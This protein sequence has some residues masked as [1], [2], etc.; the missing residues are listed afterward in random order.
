M[1][2]DAER[3]DGES[4]ANSASVAG[5]AARWVIGVPGVVLSSVLFKDLPLGLPPAVQ[6]P[7]IFALCAAAIV[8]LFTRKASPIRRLTGMPIAILGAALLSLILPIALVLAR[9]SSDLLGS[10]I[11]GAAATTICVTAVVATYGTHWAW[12]LVG[13]GLLLT[14]ASFGYGVLV[15][16]FQ[17]WAA[18]VA[19][20][21]FFLAAG[22]VLLMR[23]S[24]DASSELVPTPSGR[25]STRI[26]I[27]LA[28][29]LP[30]TAYT[31]FSAFLLLAPLLAPSAGWTV[32][33]FAAAMTCVGVAG[34]LN[35]A[36]AVI[37]STGLRAIAY[38]GLGVGI[39]ANVAITLLWVT[40]Q[41]L[42]P[43]YA[44]AFQI[45]GI[46]I[47]AILAAGGGLIA[48]GTLHFGGGGR[49]GNKRSRMNDWL[50]YWVTPRSR[51]DD[52]S[53]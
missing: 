7:L 51:P 12:A 10:T 53:A 20:A 42:R 44:E 47:P 43:A 15:S 25:T 46:M 31:L 1:T 32:F 34:M 28:W 19:W 39:I 2:D 22:I 37:R 3:H 13:T 33:A 45:F 48:V 4:R 29:L 14:G 49:G 11:I 30:S 36:A 26:L 5:K 9:L 8:L 27:G 35:G 6:V 24:R 50:R 17:P 21:I 16:S 52:P 41:E 38:I 40:S 18:G 23:R